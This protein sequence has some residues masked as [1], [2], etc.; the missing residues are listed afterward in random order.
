M[1]DA[2][3]IK[4]YTEAHKRTDGL[5]VLERRAECHS[6]ALENV[7]PV[8]RDAEPFVGSKTR[9]VRGAI[10]YCNYACQYILREFRKE[11]H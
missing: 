8:I 10:P 4:F 9:Y 5:H 1:I 2:E 3:Y 6:Y 11:D 7:T